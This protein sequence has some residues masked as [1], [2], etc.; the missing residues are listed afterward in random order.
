MFNLNDTVETKQI[1]KNSTKLHHAIAIFREFKNS[2]YPTQ[3]DIFKF[4]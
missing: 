4:L 2:L 3:T 1:Y